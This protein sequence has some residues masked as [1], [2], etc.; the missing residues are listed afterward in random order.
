[1]FWFSMLAGCQGA[2]AVHPSPTFAPSTPIIS[3]EAPAVTPTPF[4]TRPIATLTPAVIPTL[5]EVPIALFGRIIDGTGADIPLAARIFTLVDH[6][7]ALLSDRPYRE[8][9]E[10]ARVVAYLHEQSGKIFDPELADIFLK[11]VRAE[12]P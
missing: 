12:Q 1:M 8:A 3:F 6:Y 11:V 10:H 2:A 7:D 5:E 4:A 9:W